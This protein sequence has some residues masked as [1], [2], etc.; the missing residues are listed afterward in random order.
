MPRVYFVYFL[1][2]IKIVL[3]GCFHHLV[4]MRDVD[5]KTPTLESVPVV[6]AFPKVFSD[7]FLDIHLE[8]E[9]D[10]GIDRLPIMQ[11][12]SFCPYRLELVELKKLKHLLNNLLYKRF[13]DRIS[14]HGCSRVF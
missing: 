1:K 12:I 3:K 10:F 11:P 5:S 4:R 13:I 14:L 9:I 8:R 7:D 6:S 2:A